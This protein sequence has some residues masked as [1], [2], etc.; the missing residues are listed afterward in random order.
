MNPNR[1]G[2]LYLFLHA[3][4]PFVR[5]PQCDRFLEENWLFEALTETY[6][7]LVQVMSRL[8]EKGMPGVLNLSV[9]PTLL[10]MLSDELLLSRYSLHLTKL[11]ELSEKEMKRLSNDPERLDV[12]CF[13]HNR[14]VE[15]IEMWEHRLRRDIISEFAS[16]ERRGKLSLLTCVGTHPFLPAYQAEPDSIRFQLKLTVHSFREFFGKDPKGV[17]LPECGYFNGLD[18]ILAEQNIKYFFLETHGA[19]LAAPPPKYGVFAPFKT[20]AGLLCMGREQSSSVEVWSRNRGYPGHPDYREFYKDVSKEL[21]RNYLGNYFF[22]GDSPID[23]G[24]KYYR[25]TGGEQKELYHPWQ[26]MN[27]AREHARLF[28]SNRESTMAALAPEMESH[29]PCILCPYDAELFGHW[30]YEGPQFIESVFERVAISKILELGS[31]NALKLDPGDTEIHNPVFSSW[32]ENGFASVWVNPQVEYIYPMFF[33]MLAIMKECRKVKNLSKIQKRV[34]CQMYREL[35][36]FQASDWAF[37]IHNNSAA[38]Y[39]RFRLREHENSFMQ[40]YALFLGESDRES[41]LK[42]LEE[43]DNIFPWI[44]KII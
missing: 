14:L 16:L 35:A 26:A 24:F 34:L 28:V 2:Q 19:L 3:H 18:A 9:S 21:D 13:Y 22:S 31:V 8:A 20:P 15:L 23:S 33:K 5:N 37:M 10:A 12:A 43:K 39:A 6:I 4:L 40:L 11:L 36:L 42:M 17:W 44:E 27:L 41:I 29:L 38:D 30:W 1:K 7:P 32:G 25:I